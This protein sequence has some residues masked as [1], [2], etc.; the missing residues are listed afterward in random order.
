MSNLSDSTLRYAVDQVYSEIK[1][2]E[3]DRNIEI[4]EQRLWRELSC[5]ILSSQVT[6]ELAW[7]VSTTIDKKGILTTTNTKWE[8]VAN[9]LYSILSESFYV[10]GQ[11]RRYRFPKAK[12]YQI[13]KTWAVVRSHSGTLEEFLTGFSNSMILREW[14]VRHAPGLGPKQASMFLRNTGITLELAILDRHVLRYMEFIK[15]L[16]KGDHQLATM[17]KYR[18]TEKILRCYAD[19]HGYCLGT[20]DWAIWIVMRVVRINKLTLEIDG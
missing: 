18:A 2:Q 6:Y 15:L 5:C 12:S 7:S 1:S 3:P 14:M 8:V 13:A 17:Q 10:A 4:D 20:L 19:N 16:E 9:E 11:P